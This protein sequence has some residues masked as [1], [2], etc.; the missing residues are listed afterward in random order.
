MPNADVATVLSRLDAVKDTM[1]VRRAFGEPY[2]VNGVTL[3]PVAKVGGG[4]GG[5]G[6]EGTA[7]GAQ[8]SGTGAGMGFGVGVKPLGVYAVKDGHVVWRPAVDV[9]RVVLGG[10]LLM[11]AAILA[12][13]SV[14][15]RRRKK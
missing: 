13:R 1:N 3:I 6:G 14:L 10:Q 11:L 9:M 12:A 7:E 4:G 8:G 2:Q 15:L 5:G